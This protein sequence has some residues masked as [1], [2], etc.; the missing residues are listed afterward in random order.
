MRLVQGCVRVKH[1]NRLT[2]KVRKEGQS[3]MSALVSLFGLHPTCK[4][5]LEPFCMLGPASD[6]LLSDY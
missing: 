5:S 1:F 4:A 3:K 2:C 6:L